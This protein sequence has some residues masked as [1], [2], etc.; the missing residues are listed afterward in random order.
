MLN[1]VIILSRF[2][3]RFAIGFRSVVACVVG[4]CP[5]PRPSPSPMYASP[6]LL[7]LF[8]L[9]QFYRAA[10]P[11][12][13]PLSPTSC[14]RCSGD[15]YRRILDPKV[16]PPLLS[17]SSLP[18]LPFPTCVPTTPPP[19]RAH[20]G[21]A[22]CLARAPLGAPWRGPLGA[23][24]RGPLGPRRRG[25][26][27]PR[28]VAPSVPLGMAP[29]APGGAASLAPGGAALPAPAASPR[30]PRARQRPLR[31][32]WRGLRGPRRAA[33]SRT[34]NPSVRDI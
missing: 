3:F 16:S 6:P 12:L 23:P 2:G 10:T 8:S 5:S 22:T 11:S 31:A 19:P 1:R 24:W 26:P 9:I 32:P 28:G 21:G 25:L 34:R 30:P 14:P 20:P 13:P 7:F 4:F 18:P 15:G 29:S 27:W 33:R 17:L